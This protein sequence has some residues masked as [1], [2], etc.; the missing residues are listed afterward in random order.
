MLA[1]DVLGGDPQKVQ[2]FRNSILV[3]PDLE[4]RSVAGPQMS[5]CAPIERVTSPIS[6][7]A[8]ASSDHS[9][10]PPTPNLTQSETR[11]R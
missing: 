3:E 10:V 5:P 1:E 4:V 8:M 11:G 7:S 2:Q 9:L 6:N